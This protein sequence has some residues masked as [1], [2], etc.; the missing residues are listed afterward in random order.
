MFSHLLL[1]FITPLIPYI[2]I[3]YHAPRFRELLHRIMGVQKFPME[4]STFFCSLGG[5][6][7]TS[8]N[9]NVSSAAADTTH[10]PSGLWSM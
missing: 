1:E 2:T 8:Q 4:R 10:P 7:N 3:Y 6:P 9:L 5:L